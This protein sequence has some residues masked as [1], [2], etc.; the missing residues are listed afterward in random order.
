[1]KVMT[2]R[3]NNDKVYRALAS[4]ISYNVGE[5]LVKDLLDKLTES[6]EGLSSYDG[7]VWADDEALDQYWSMFVLMF[8]DYGTSPRFGWIKK[9]DESIQFFT[10]LYNDVKD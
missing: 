4:A 6:S 9:T 7:F 3:Y 8:G 2:E 1:M 5:E 10:D